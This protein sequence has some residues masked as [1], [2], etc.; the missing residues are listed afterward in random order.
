MPRRIPSKDHSFTALNRRRFMQSLGLATAGSALVG[1]Q[2]LP[3][4]QARKI[5]PNEKL[6]IG[7]IGVAGRGGDD[8]REVASLENI[9]ALCD[10]DSTHLAAAAQKYPSAK[11]YSD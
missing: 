2:T 5:S 10:V 8:L 6:N 1:C 9:V 11:T 7:V 4:P 3:P